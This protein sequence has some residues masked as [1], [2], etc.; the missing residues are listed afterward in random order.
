LA[1]SRVEQK[2]SKKRAKSE[3]KASKK[4]AKSEQKAFFRAARQWH[5]VKK[6]PRA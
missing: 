6:S 5:Y 2:A 4:R 3:Q 1:T